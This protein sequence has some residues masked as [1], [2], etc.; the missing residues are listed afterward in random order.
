[1]MKVRV[2]VMYCSRPIVVSGKRVVEALNISSGMA[3]TAPALINKIVT[4]IPW[5]N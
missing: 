4:E 2:G 5:P 1:M 3:V